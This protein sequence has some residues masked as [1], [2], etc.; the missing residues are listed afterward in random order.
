MNDNT[1]ILK[2]SIFTT[3]NPDDRRNISI[4]VAL[5]VFSLILFVNK[6]VHIDDTLFIRAAQQI[7][8]HPLDPYNFTVNWFGTDRP[9]YAVT[10]NPP[11]ASY[12]LACI[13]SIAGWSEP[14]LHCAMMIPA[15]V[16]IAGIY[17][18]ARHFCSKPFEAAL[19]SLFSPAFLLSSTALMCDVMM[20]CLWIW[21]IIFWMNGIRSRSRSQL[22]IA[23][24][25]IALSALTKYFGA[26]L[27]PL[28][29]VWTIAERK[30]IDSSL[31]AMII[32]VLILAGYQW[33]T[34]KYYGH[35]L[36]FDA[37]SYAADNEV[38]GFTAYVSKSF[39]GLAFTGGCFIAPLFF[40]HTLWDRKFLVR[41]GIIS[42]MILLSVVLFQSISGSIHLNEKNVPWTFV[43]QF[44]LLVLVGMIVISL[45]IA[46]F[47]KH[48]DAS[49]LMIVC[50]IVGTFLFTIFINWTVNGRS[51]LP[52]VPAAA[53]LLMR[54]YGDRWNNS[55]P[56]GTPNVIIPIII[57]AVITLT[58]TYSDFS[59]A[60]A[61]RDDVT[62]I[63]SHP[64]TPN[65]KIW[66][67]GH[68]GFQYYMETSGG[69]A[70]DVERSKL[71]R[72]DIVIV[73][74]NNTSLYHLPERYFVLSDSLQGSGGI[75]LLA[76]MNNTAGA[77]F[78]SDFWGPM[79]FVFGEIPPEKYYVYIVKEGIAIH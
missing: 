75:S 7:Q 60:N 70:F 44:S 10:K 68:W 36:L 47:R 34:M 26:A 15:I 32:P 14:V 74:L 37:A 53:I 40:F 6:A 29:T 77:G 52:L 56:N 71:D 65:S 17:L 48:R 2:N 59:L 73:P 27:I 66:F 5:T 38:R 33:L 43:F 39:V 69:K 61:I 58:V 67:E 72:G 51:I 1:S 63:W 79:P 18:L 23:S 30:R 16:C 50:W 13:G 25:L 11:L 78:Y 12:Y 20:L 49:S 19:I 54:R 55:E 45:A 3:V 4:L 22:V 41:A 76:T 31:I 62:A 57:C 24:F 64:R 35:G 9:M 46:D 28:L 8:S 42:G 21:S